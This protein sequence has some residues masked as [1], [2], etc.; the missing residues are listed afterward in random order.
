M[1]HD[2]VFAFNQLHDSGS[3]PQ[4]ELHLQLLR[5]FVADGALNCLLLLLRQGSIFATAPTTPARCKRSLSRL[6]ETRNRL[7]DSRVTESDFFGNL[8]S[9]S[10]P[11]VSPYDLSAP[12]VL[13]NRTEFFCIVFFHATYGSVDVDKFTLF[14]GLIY[15]DVHS[16]GKQT[17]VPMDSA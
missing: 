9:R 7:A 17:Y 14:V 11:F 6:L 5:T 15:R 8:G 16:I 2:T 3:A 1:Q 10:P 13:L 4:C 12:L